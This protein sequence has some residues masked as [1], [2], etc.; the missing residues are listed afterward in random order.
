MELQNAPAVGDGSVADKTGKAAERQ[1]KG[2][3]FDTR[4]PPG[5]DTLDLADAESLRDALCFAY[6]EATEWVDVDRLVAE[7]Q[8]PDTDPAD[9]RRYYL[10]VA[11][12]SSD[13]AFDR[14]AWDNLGA[15]G[16]VPAD[17]ELVVLG[18]DGAR[19]D[20][21]T[22]L[23]GVAV[24]S[25]VAWSI[26]VWERP[27]REPDWEVPEAEVTAA[28]AE[29]FDRWAVWRL[30]ADPPYWEPTI[31]A[32]A[33]KFKG[34]DRKPAVFEWW[35]NRW[36][37]VGYACKGLASAIRAGEI[38]H[39]VDTDDA[40]SRHMRNAVRRPIASRDDQGLPLWTLAK[41]A[42]NR[43]ID[44]AMALTLA[45]EARTDAITAGAKRRGGGAKFF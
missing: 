5:A 42:P 17:R 11:A 41:P 13:W 22:A 30:Y 6:G 40:L 24:E 29:A 16:L 32:W 4:E 8:D 7:I 44:G 14:T 9:A 38:H 37:Q 21:A 33:A 18:F 26:G 31:A 27:D 1:T 20:D 10:N 36:R 35:T 25:G 19:F 45:W 28:V 34:T 23:V 2:V 12:P 39:H 3:L 15:P 43:K